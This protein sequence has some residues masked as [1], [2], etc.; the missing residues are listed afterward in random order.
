MGMPPA[1]AKRKHDPTIPAHIDQSR[2]PAGLYWDRTGKG[3]WRARVYKDGRWALETV[4]GAQARL[5]DLHA[6]MEQGRDAGPAHGS[7]AW[8]LAAFHG[9]EKFKSLA[10]ATRRDYAICRKHVEGYKTRSGVLL[11]TLDARRL[12]P[13]NI[14]AVHD[15][16]VRA[17]HPAKANHVLRYLRRVYSWAR[18]P[19]GIKDNPAKGVEAA[20][21]RRR[22]GM[23][24][25]DVFARV[26]AFARDRAARTAHTAG[27]VAPYLPAIMEVAY[28]LRLR[29]I[30]AVTLTDANATEAGIVSN[31]RKGSNDNVTTWTPRLRAA[32]DEAAELRRIAM[33]R[34][35]RPVQLRP[36][37]RPLFVS[38]DG[39]PLSRSGLTNAFR[40]LM[41]AATL[42]EDQGG[43][44]TP[45]QR[46]TLHGLKHRGVT[47][48]KGTKADK[49]DASGHRTR[50]M[51]DHYDH[52][53]PVVKPAGEG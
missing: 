17:G 38:E 21:E 31:R 4:A 1:G 28:G 39:Y 19:L 29:G 27:S 5:S 20:P 2:L 26:L 46:F 40:R 18:V 12:T 37:D 53:L 50:A 10:A 13:A 15:R 41:K 44:I 49:Q 14:Y 34:N 24:A 48:T 6:I 45:D 23:P 32:W 11:A 16:F 43:V 52:E 9:S 30:E 7:V 3:R 8:M 36:E 51:V 42:P 35:R 22:N 25:A 47:D 33:E